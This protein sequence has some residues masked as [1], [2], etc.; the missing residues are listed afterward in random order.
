MF[1][2]MYTYVIYISRQLRTNEHAQILINI[3]IALMCLYITFLVGLHAAPVPV[4]CGIFA[5]LLQYFMLA[6][7]V[8]SAVEAFYLYRK[9]VLV[10]GTHI[11]K[12]VLK[13]ALIAWCK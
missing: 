9:L 11:Q 12:F 1:I 4:L 8:W 2:Y 6:F 5:A 7:V 10:L 13:A 3:A